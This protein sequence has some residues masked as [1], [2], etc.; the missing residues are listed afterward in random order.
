MKRTL[1]KNLCELMKSYLSNEIL[2]F[3]RASR[4][5]HDEA[6][7]GY[8][9]IAAGVLHGSLLGPLLYL[10]YTADILL[11]AGTEMAILLLMTQPSQ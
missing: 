2:P 7:S 1:Q 9:P 8:H 11:T 4:I 5:V 3:E 10:L 6:K